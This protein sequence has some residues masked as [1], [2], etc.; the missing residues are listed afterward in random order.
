M[1]DYKPGSH[2]NF[3]YGKRAPRKENC[4][5]RIAMRARKLCVPEIDIGRR[6]RFRTAQ[7]PTVFPRRCDDVGW[8]TNDQERRIVNG[9]ANA[10]TIVP[11]VAFA[12]RTG[13]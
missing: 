5:E 7:Q 9:A 4:S 8:S 1:T 11:A 2:G 12:G 3:T 13:D 10:I 6:R